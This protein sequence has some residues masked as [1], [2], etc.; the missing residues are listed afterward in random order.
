MYYSNQCASG[1]NPMQSKNLLETYS[2]FCG[3]FG[4]VDPDPT[5]P[6][7]LE[8]L[9]FLGFSRFFRAWI[10]MTF[11]FC[12]LELILTS[13]APDL[14]RKTITARKQSSQTKSKPWSMPQQSWRK[15]TETCVNIDHHNER[16]SAFACVITARLM[17]Q[18]MHTFGAHLQPHRPCERS[19]RKQS[20]R[21]LGQKRSGI[22]G[23]F[24]GRKPKPFQHALDRRRSDQDLIF[25][26]FV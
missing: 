15:S 26:L 6:A 2:F 3:S 20:G 8:A 25:R 14:W 18:S 7:P 23:R 21:K 4:A 24:P 1:C 16:T 19:Y 13:K 22:Y 5:P 12:S 10:A 9:F 17:S 11:R